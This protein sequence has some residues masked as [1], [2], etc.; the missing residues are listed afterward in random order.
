MSRLHLLQAN[1]L[2]AALTVVVVS[3]ATLHPTPTEA[4]A[5]HAVSHAG[6]G[7][8]APDLAPGRQVAEDTLQPTVFK[9][10]WRTFKKILSA[11]IDFID[12]VIDTTVELLVDVAPA[13]SAHPEKWSPTRPTFPEPRPL[14]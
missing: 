14:A 8:S 11:L 4:R 3:A 13:G 10:W 1:L 7:G 9:S 6:G 5:M 2:T 12:R